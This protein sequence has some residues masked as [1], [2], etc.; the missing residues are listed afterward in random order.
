MSRISDLIKEG[1]LKI[2]VAK[3]PYPKCNRCW[4]HTEDVMYSKYWLDTLCGRCAKV[5]CTLE[6]EGQ[7]FPGKQNMITF[8]NK[9]M[10]YPV[11]HVESEEQAISN[12]KIAKEAGCDGVFLI[13]H[14]ITP[15]ELLVIHAA[16][17]KAVPNWWIGINCLGMSNVAIIEHATPEISGIWVDNAGIDEHSEDQPMASLYQSIQKNSKWNGI[18]FGGVAFKYQRPVEDLETACKFAKQYIDVVTTSGP[19]T[20][21]AAAVDKIKRMSDTLGEWP[22]AIASGI[23]PD[24]IEDYLDKATCFLVASGINKTWADLDPELVKQLV[25]KIR[26]YDGASS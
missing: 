23:T 5:L 25:D 13:N 15:E 1:R 4:N 18:Y 21:K 11:I 26:G 8:K 2:E 12:T 14:G 7:W 16:V 22:L 17:A 19:G 6:E 9:H 10:I 20:A 3:S 24:N